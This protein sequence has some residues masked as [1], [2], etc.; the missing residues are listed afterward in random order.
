M[1]ST[2]PPEKFKRSIRNYLLDSR[3][4]L[5]YTGWMLFGAIIISAVLGTF[6]LKTSNEVVA[7]S[8]K[9]A[10]ESKKVSDVMKMQ[11]KDDPVYALDPVLAKAVGSAAS[12]SD[13]EV[14][15]QQRALLQKQR[16]MLNTVIGALLAL[17]VLIG[18][19]GIY[20]THK[21]VGPIYM[22]KLLLKQVGDGKLNFNRKPRKGDELQDFFEAFS[23]MVEKLKKRQRLE[24]ERLEDAIDAAKAQGLSKEAIE[25][26]EAIKNEMRRPLEE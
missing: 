18:A 8:E 24:V 4:Q 15:N 1:N 20:T 19:L 5:K 10:A 9:V 11:V 12:S 3:F 13:A 22:M 21:I 23:R 26:F 2:A 14:Q 7:Q 25:R 16:G 17:V 6:L